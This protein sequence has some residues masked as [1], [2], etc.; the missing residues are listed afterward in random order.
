MNLDRRLLGWGLFFIILGGVPLAVRAGV[1]TED[2]VGR[3]PTLWPL[4]LIAWGLGMILHRT[5]LNWVGGGVFAVTLGLMGGGAITTGLTGF[6]GFTG[7]GGGGEGGTAFASQSGTLGSEGRVNVEFSCGDLDVTTADGSD[8]SVSGTDRDG[9]GPDVSTGGSSVTI[10]SRGQEGFF[11]PLDGTSAWTVTIP[12]GPDLA[13]GVTLNA[14]EGA[15]DLAGA[16]LSSMNFTVNGGSLDI[17][18]GSAGRLSSLNGTVNAGSAVIDLPGGDLRVNLSLNA[19]S[20]DVC[21]PAGAA[22][23]VQW[24]GAL[25]SN[26]LDQAGLVKVDDDTWQTPGFSSTQPHA[27]LNVSANVGSFGLQ[28]G[29]SCGA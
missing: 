29:G 19:G 23:T 27:A 20:M 4:F 2:V 25:G 12:R 16:T 21:L 7:C 5:P 18:L 8:W 14:G 6:S 10:R 1:V 3:W 11:N 26:D 17:D 13:F 22:A 9:R 24:S 28:L 15:V